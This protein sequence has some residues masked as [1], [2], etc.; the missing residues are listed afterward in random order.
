MEEFK[1]GLYLA[2][3]HFKAKKIEKDVTLC[4]Q[5][6]RAQRIFVDWRTHTSLFFIGKIL[7]NMLSLI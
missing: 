4:F 2:C 6:P 7:T 1:T 3:V 5:L